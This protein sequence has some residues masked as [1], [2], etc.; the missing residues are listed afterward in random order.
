[1]MRSSPSINFSYVSNM[2][3]RVLVKEDLVYLIVAAL[4]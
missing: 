1:M 4:S 2:A 3:V